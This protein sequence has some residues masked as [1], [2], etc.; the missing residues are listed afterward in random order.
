MGVR[1]L[2]NRVCSYVDVNPEL[3]DVEV[4]S[5][6]HNELRNH[7]PFY[8]S[9]PNGSKGAGTAIDTNGF[10]IRVTTSQLRDP[11]Y[12]VAVIAHEIGHV[13]LTKNSKIT[14]DTTD[15]EQLADLLTVFWGLGIFTANA[16]FK[17]TQWSGGGKY[18][19]SSRRHGYLSEQMFGYSLA[20]FAW[21][22]SE[23]KPHWTNHLEVNIKH[24]FKSG[25]RYLEKT[26]DTKLKKLMTTSF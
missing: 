26:G 7:L 23:V 8:E 22:R 3:I 5:D 14:P 16:A 18:G 2:L 21:I 1:K 12:I 10:K 24:Y 25:L 17:F 20:L 15:F 4:Y 19:W 13:L 6:A 11:S 9:S